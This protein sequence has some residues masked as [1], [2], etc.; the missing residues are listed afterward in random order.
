MK[1]LRFALLGLVVALAFSAGVWFSSGTVPSQVP[2]GEGAIPPP[3]VASTPSETR[4][5]PR[6]SA[7]PTRASPATE[8]P[9]EATVLRR[10]PAPRDVRAEQPPTTEPAPETLPLAFAPELPEPFT[11]KGFERVA[12]RAAN[13]CG[14]GLDVVAVD[15]SEFPCIAWTR[16]KDDTVKKFS[17]EECEPWEEAFQHRTMVVASGQWKEGGPGAGT[18]HGCR[19]PRTRSSTASPCGAPGSA[20]MA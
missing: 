6:P 17:M 16:A 8:S 4:T 5:A 19:C 14:M 20:P 18:W 11:P 7:A 9:T 13:E 3:A 1:L 2:S 10:L 15:C 12:F